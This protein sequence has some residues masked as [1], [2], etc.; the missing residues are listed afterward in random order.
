MAALTR[1]ASAAVAP[2]KP[3]SKRNSGV[4][5]SAAPIRRLSV[6][7][8]AE[9]AKPIVHQ[10]PPPPIQEQEEPERDDILDDYLDS[11]ANDDEVEAAAP[12]ASDR[13]HVTAWAEKTKTPTP[14]SR[15]VSVA[16]SMYS[17]SSYGGGGSPRR[18]GT[19]RTA[20]KR[21][22]ASYDDEE[23][24]YGS[25]EDDA[26][27]ELVKIR[28]KL[29]YQDDIR[30]MALDPE[31][32]FEEFLDLVTAKFGRSMDGLGMKFK[33]EDGGKV[34]M[35]DESDYAMAIETARES[36]QGKAEGKLEIWC[37]DV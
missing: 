33:D 24:G 32:Q 30:G 16:G 37:T 18:R 6:R 20:A 15:P 26:P 35:R 28:V 7:Q 12:Q 23:E 9:V 36:A 31:A 2:L 13:D 17:A 21:A 14:A 5:L 22:P 3:L 19:R 25:G 29:H 4:P 11:Y 8:P 27:F 10:P 34:S 1:S